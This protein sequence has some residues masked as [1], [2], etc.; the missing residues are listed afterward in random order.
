MRLM[1][2]LVI[3]VSPE[4]SIDLLKGFADIVVLDKEPVPNKLPSYET[5][6]IRS[7]FGQPATLPEVFRS[8]IEDIVQRAKYENPD[9][10]FIDNTD[11]VDK[12]L[13]AEDKWNQYE[14]FSNFMPKN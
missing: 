13:G 3:T 1:K 12:V 10:K 14:I 4:S 11:T 9:I 8:K 6:Y 7:H 2:N 5:L